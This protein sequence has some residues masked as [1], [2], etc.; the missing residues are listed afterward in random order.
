VVAE[1]FR[2]ALSLGWGDDGDRLA[3][4]AAY[5][6]NERAASFYERAGFVSTRSRSRVDL[7]TSKN[8]R[9]FL[10]TWLKGAR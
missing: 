7:T 3:V 8:V 4:V 9:R 2:V 5:V 6:T 10:T 1:T